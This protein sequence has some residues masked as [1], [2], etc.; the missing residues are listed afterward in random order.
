MA[1]QMIVVSVLLALSSDDTQYTLDI[2]CS[3]GMHLS[4]YLYV[5]CLSTINPLVVENIN[6]LIR[7]TYNYTVLSDFWSF[8]EGKILIL[9][10]VDNNQSGLPNSKQ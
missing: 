8:T 4:I 6:L 5:L 10:H 3:L 9:D 1:A 7:H 2:R